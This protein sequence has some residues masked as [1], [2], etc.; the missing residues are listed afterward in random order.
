MDPIEVA[1]ARQLAVAAAPMASVTETVPLAASLGRI[2][3]TN[4]FALSPS[5]PFA[6]SAM[7]GIALRHRDANDVLPVSDTVLAGHSI[8]SLPLGHCMK[9]MTGAPVPD[10]ADAVVA[11][12][13]IEF[14]DN[15]ARISGEVR[16][17]QN[18]RPAGEDF[19][20]GDTVVGKGAM[21]GVSHQAALAATGHHQ[22][23]VFA[24]PNVGLLTTGAELVSPGGKLIPGSIYD[25][26]SIMMASIIQAAGA[27]VSHY[28]VGDDAQSTRRLAQELTAKHDAVVSVGGVSVGEADVVKDVVSELGQLKLWR[29]MMK[30]G[31]PF[32]LGEVNGRPWYGLPGNPVSSLICF[33]MIVLPAIW[34]LQGR[35]Q[36]FPSGLPARLQMPVRKRTPRLEYQR[37][38]WTRDG[39][40]LNVRPVSAQGSGQLSGLSSA[41]CLIELAA[42]TYEFDAGAVV[43]IYPF[44]HLM[45]GNAHV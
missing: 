29:I 12:E 8:A 14:V 35:E 28:R 37:G 36:S 10:G 31:K 43:T 5:P 27:T 44:C 30:P 16:H 17:G 32:M 26:N 23:Q 15:Q 45:P 19:A 25:S 2:C 21:I 41:D 9:I 11:R 13:T 42:N 39:D 3:A 7:D 33:L 18:I 34:R 4:V 22:V 6:N 24:R 40:R 38:Q 20:L 1:T